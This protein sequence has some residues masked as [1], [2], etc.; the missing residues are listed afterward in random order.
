MDRQPKYVVHVQLTVDYVPQYG[1]EVG[2]DLVDQAPLGP[3]AL[4]TED[5]LW[6]AG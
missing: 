4:G 5:H 6:E 2:R 3:L 1:T